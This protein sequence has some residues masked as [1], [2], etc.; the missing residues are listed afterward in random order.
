MLFS[1][2]LPGDYLEKSRPARAKMKNTRLRV[3]VPLDIIVTKIGRLN[4][5]DKEDVMRCI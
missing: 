5:R 2:D 3:L 4:E 1:Q